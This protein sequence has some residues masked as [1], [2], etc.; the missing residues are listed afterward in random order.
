MGAADW[1]RAPTVREALLWEPLAGGAVACRLCERRCVIAPGR[2]G[3]CA[4]RLNYGGRLL[5]LAYGDLAAL[6]SRPIEIKPFFHYWPGSTALTYTTWSCNLACAWCQNHGL[7][8]RRPD[9]RRA[10]FFPPPDLVAL[11]RAG[12]DQGLCVSFTEPTLLFEHCCDTF[13]VA[14]S[15]GLYCCFVSNGRMTAE[16]LAMLAARGL[17]GLKVDVKGPPEVYRRFCGAEDGIVPWD[18]IHQAKGRYFPAHRFKAPATPV[19]VLEQACRMARDAG[20]DFAYLGNVAGHPWEDTRCP[21][22]GTLLLQ[23]YGA[24]LVQSAVTPRGTCSCCERPLPLRGQV[25]A[26]HATG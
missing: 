4:T 24:A 1:Q 6:E 7:S 13:P 8:R 15:E 17:D 25:G 5:T 21:G 19:R 18:R 11:A 2:L 26:G 14:R 10:Q 12:G 22:C 9:P 3:T 20:V 23:R 16:A